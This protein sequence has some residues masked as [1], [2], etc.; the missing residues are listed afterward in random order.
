MRF[1]LEEI[2]NSSSLLPN[3]TLG[4]EIYDTCSESANI[5]ATLRALVQKGRHDIEVLHAFQHYEP[6]AVA[7]IGP[8]STQLAL[9]TAAILGV[10]LVPELLQKIKQVNFSLHN[11]QICFDANGN[12]NKGYDI[13]MWN[14]RGLSWAFDVVGTFTVNPDRL[15]LNRSKILWHTKDHQAPIS[16]CSQPC[17][18]GE[19][20]LQQNRHRCCFSCVAC[21]AGTF[22]NRTGREQGTPGLTAV[23]CTASSRREIEPG[24]AFVPWIALT[25]VVTSSSHVLRA[26]ENVPFLG[27]AA[28]MP[29][30]ISHH[31]KP[32]CQHVLLVPG[33]P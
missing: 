23:S 22:L 21:P 4:Y 28:G 14:W 18:A 17:A 12:I 19:K 20:R 30:L 15:L 2:N 8:D 6:T 27:P 10:F 25:I 31:D 7:V 11:S 5:Y 29:C 32:P 24:V 33:Q 26:Y 9:T 3:V 1:A 16:M 13:I